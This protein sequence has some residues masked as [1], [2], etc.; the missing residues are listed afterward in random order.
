MDLALKCSYEFKPLL[1]LPGSSSD[2]EGEKQM[3]KKLS[4]AL[5]DENQM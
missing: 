4:R 1:I 2:L 5:K 3:Q